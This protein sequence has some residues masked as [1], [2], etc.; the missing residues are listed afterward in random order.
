[1]LTNESLAEP[2][3]FQL[4]YLSGYILGT[5][6]EIADGFTDFPRT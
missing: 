4:I 1:M 3:P 5:P 2:M 6:A